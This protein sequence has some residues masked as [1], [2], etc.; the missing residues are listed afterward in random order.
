MAVDHS[1]SLSLCVWVCVS[2]SL[3][4]SLWERV[5]VLVV[6]MKGMEECTYIVY[7]HCCLDAYTFVCLQL[8]GTEDGKR[9]LASQ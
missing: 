9:Q 6:E 7:V 2:H 8:A 3:S 4:L 5:G 1:L